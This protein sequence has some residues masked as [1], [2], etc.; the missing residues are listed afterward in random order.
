MVQ[1]QQFQPSTESIDWSQSAANFNPSPEF[2]REV[3][4][5][6]RIVEAAQNGNKR[7]RIA[8]EEAM[9]TA[10]FPSL[11]GYALSR[12]VQAFYSEF[13]APWQTATRRVD[14]PDFRERE[15]YPNNTIDN[16]LTADSDDGAPAAPRRNKADS[17]PTKWRLN[18]YRA[19]AELTWRTLVNDDLNFFSQIPQEF[20][21][22][23][24]RTELKLFTQTH[25]GSTGPTGLTQITNNPTLSVSNLKAA[26]T[27]MMKQVDGN[28]E[29]VSIGAPILE[30]GPGLAVTASEIVQATALE[31][32]AGTGVTGIRQTRNW[33]SDFINSI[34][35]NPYVPVVATTNGDTS[36]CLLASSA[37][38]PA[39]F[40]H[41]WLQGMQGPQLLMKAPDVMRVGGGIDGRFGSFDTLS[42]KYQVVLAFGIKLLDSKLGFMSNGTGS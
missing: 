34:I 10:D 6:Y 25:W 9:T 36:W 24:R 7:A 21:R 26:V 27:Q 14:L 22:A 19:M 12:D 18:T 30:V 35:I 38:G 33:V 28:G 16:V 31:I 5:T 40:E 2:L 1:I 39:A 15:W 41:G 42:T 23:A 13:P 29:P 11:F 8:L 20:A 32:S 4:K 37:A 3:Q 17:I